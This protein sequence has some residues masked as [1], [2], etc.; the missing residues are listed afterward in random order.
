MKSERYGIIVCPECHNARVVD[1]SNKTVSC[2]HCGKRL[3]I[4]KMKLYYETDSQ[5]EA[6]WAVGRINAKMEDGEL[7]EK[8]EKEKDVYAKALESSSVGD[9]RRERLTALAK[10]LSRELGE[11]DEEDIKV[12][13]ERADLGS[14]EDI[15]EDLRKID[16]VYEPRNRVFKTVD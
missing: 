9:N 12:I 3:K 11:F 1:L 8:E 15:I 5:K 6:S 16:I 7:P 2:S 13:A 14:E 4:K 10:V